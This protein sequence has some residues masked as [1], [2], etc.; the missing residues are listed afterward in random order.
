[1]NVDFIDVQHDLAGGKILDQPLDFPQSTSPTPLLPRA[2]NDRLGPPQPDSRATKE[3]AH[4]GDA[5]RDL[6]PFGQ[7]Q[8]QQLLSPSRSPVA[9]I[10]WQ[11]LDEPE[12]FALV[13][14]CDLS[15]A[16]V[17]T[18]IGEPHQT[19]ADEP[20]GDAVYLG[21]RAEAA[22]SDYGRSLALNKGEYHL[23]PTPHAGVLRTHREPPKFL[24]LG[25][26]H[27]LPRVNDSRSKQGGTPFTGAFADT[28]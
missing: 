24:P 26:R 23:S 5:D 15:L 3:P 28:T 7:D 6:D 12:Q 9:E 16:T 17:L 14:W 25:L 13:D 21:L 1:M 27:L 2:A 10:L 22:L 4:G 19:V 18:P 11:L 8:D 20:R